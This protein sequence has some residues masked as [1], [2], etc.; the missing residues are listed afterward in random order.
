MQVTF[1]PT[2][3]ED[4]AAVSA[5]L[6][7]LDAEPNSEAKT[8]KRTRKSKEEAPIP[9]T[10]ALDQAV[11]PAPAPVAQADTGAYAMPPVPAFLDR[12]QQAQPPAPI[13]APTG[14]TKLQV[15]QAVQAFTTEYKV[16]AA[17][18]RL[19]QLAKACGL[20]EPLAIDAIPEAYYPH[21][22]EYFKVVK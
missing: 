8:Q 12:A 4:V 19:S 20:A 22:L 6:G 14:I 2:S 13:V 3:Q 5:L 18:E 15:T 16:A 11:P 17:K 1:D 7:A 9:Q 21:A 10:A